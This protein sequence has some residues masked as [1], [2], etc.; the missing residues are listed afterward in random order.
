M[1]ELA[2]GAKI[3]TVMGYPGGNDQIDLAVEKGEIQCRGNTILPH[4]GREPFDTWHKKGFDRTL[5]LF[6]PRA[7]ATR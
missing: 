2:L 6:K 3:N 1:L 4:F 5:I 7:N